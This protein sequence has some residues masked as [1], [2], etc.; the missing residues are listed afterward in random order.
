MPA[1]SP[2][3]LYR[4]RG[5]FPDRSPIAGMVEEISPGEVET[6]LEEEDVQI[7]DIRDPRSYREGH[8]PG[9]ENLP[10]NRFAAEV[11][12]VE[13]GEKVVLACQIG[14]SSVKA[15]RLLES[16]EGLSAD[17]DVASMAGGYEEWDSDLETGS[18]SD[19]DSGADAGA[20]DES[21]APF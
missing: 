20:G 7:V 4:E 19:A 17:A 3:R 8:I 13:W 9:A 15:A 2:F 6:K 16:Y 10:A 21:A 12:A 18:E 14:E 5:A 11:D 1:P